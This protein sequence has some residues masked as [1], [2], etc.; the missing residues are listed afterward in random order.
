MRSAGMPSSLPVTI[1]EG[2]R[3]DAAVLAGFGAATFRAAYA[4]DVP[5]A[6]LD[7]YIA[8]TFGVAL[9][10][11]ELNDPACRF[12]LAELDDDLLGYALLQE[13]A[14]SVDIPGDRPVLLDRLY[15]APVAQ[16][17]GVGGALL[18]R[19]LREV[20]AK[21]Q[22]V[23]WLSVWEQ[24]PRAIAVYRRWGFVDVGEIAFDLAG[25]PQ[26]DRVLALPCA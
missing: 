10:L 24:N 4:I 7:D 11:A 22:D 5:A 2:E 13:A 1:R 25:E 21:G 8:R 26:L 17:R 14:P 16:G 15:V 18:D 6:A 12:L 23:L 9:Q 19:A 20:R 3:A